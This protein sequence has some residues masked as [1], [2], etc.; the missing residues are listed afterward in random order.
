MKNTFKEKNQNSFQKKLDWESVQN[1]MKQKFGKDIYDS[2]LKKIELI[3]E[4][5]EM[6]E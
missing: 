4:F 2:W 3:D 5:D 6:K 1:E